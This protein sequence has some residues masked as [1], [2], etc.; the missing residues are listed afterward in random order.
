MVN[1]T[2]KYA[3]INIS[4]RRIVIL[5]LLL[6][7]PFFMYAEVVF[8][9]LHLSSENQLVFS[10]KADSP[11]YGTYTTAFSQVLD[12]DEL[13][14]LSFFPEKVTY[15]E[16][17]KQLQIQNRF[18][19]FR[20]TFSESDEI[21]AP[22]SVKEFPS[23]ANG[24]E[25]YSGKIR[26]VGSSPDGRHVLFIRSNEYAYGSLVL[27]EVESGKTRTISEDITISYEEPSALWSPDSRYFV[28]Q[29][30]AELYYFSMNQLQRNE[31]MNEEM[32]LIGEG[33]LANVQWTEQNKLYY[34]D[35]S[36]L[37]RIFST[38]FFTRSFYSDLLDAG[39][40]IG[41]VP[42]EFDSN[43]DSFYVS[44]DGAK[45]LFNKGGRN[46]ILYFMKN[47]DYLSTGS[48]VSLP[49]LYLPRN[50]RIKRLLWS[51]KDLITVLT[52]SIQ[53]GK[54][55]SSL[56][57]LDIG[58]QQNSDSLSFKRL[59]AEE[60][61]DIVLAPGGRH[62]ALMYPDRVVIKGYDTW[63]TTKTL[64]H[65]KPMHVNWTAEDELI[66]SGREYIKRYRLE[67]RDDKLITISQAGTYGYSEGGTIYT[68]IAGEQYKLDV[69][70][71]PQLAKKEDI[72][73]V[74]SKI[75]NDN[76]RV[77]LNNNPEGHS[78]ENMIMVRHIQEYKTTPLC[79]HAGHSYEPFPEKE[80]AV[81]FENFTHGSRIRRREVALVFNAVDSIEGLTEILNTLHDYGIKCTFFVNGEFMR[82]NP[83]AVVE[84]AKSDHEV[85]SLF[86]TYFNMT[87]A[88][89]Q[90]T[91]D[92]IKQGLARNEDE[93]FN[94]T[95]DESGRGKE[96]SLLWH[97]PY[98]FVNNQIIEASS[99]M[100]Y[101][102]IGHDVDPLDWVPRSEN[103]GMYRPSPELVERVLLKKKPGSIIP[104]RIGKVK[105]GRDDY[106]FQYLDLLIDGLVSKGYKV[107][108]VSTLVEH[109]R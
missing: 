39:Q 21:A 9:G 78:Y 76:Y 52:G 28:Y 14:Q 42:F 24:E 57:R 17:S 23:F 38:E 83:E 54:S 61:K 58:A 37:Y 6:M 50:T 31:I 15:L 3:E 89:Y 22:K 101:T 64:Q 79:P 81:N 18:G 20:T 91:K 11:R 25:I 56:F 51:D 63:H 33:T 71:G 1:L 8:E 34:I 70:R 53:G 45:L 65:S 95:A 72:T 26:Q 93:Y 35:E 100:N 86:Y 4:M 109:A 49:Y 106:L 40:V 5:L 68:T 90:I 30:N 67:E 46:L 75:A 73:L 59:D 107:V 105:G 29:K 102:Y 48:T 87:D 60:V 85:G 47:D 74:P 36:V 82:R 7:A 88:R 10:V 99:E 19:I 12:G 104:I 94:I 16:K 69:E 97:S 96:L 55:S 43:F 103:D 32:R 27:L 66:V 98:Y 92:F 44:P 62:T 77:Y 84:L 108:P 41:K 80:E 13:Q 2:S